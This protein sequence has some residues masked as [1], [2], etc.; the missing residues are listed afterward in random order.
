MQQTKY[1]NAKIPNIN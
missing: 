1:N